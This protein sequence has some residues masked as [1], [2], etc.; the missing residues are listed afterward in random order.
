[1]L[2]RVLAGQPATIKVTF[3]DHNGEPRDA[4]DCTANA[5]RLDGT[6]MSL[7]TPSPGEGVGEFTISL[8]VAQTASLD[9][10][11][12][13]CVETATNATA[14]VTVEIVG[15][16]Y[17]SV[18]EARSTID[19][20]KR[21]DD[22]PTEDVVRVRAE[23]EDE[24]ERICRQAFVPRVKRV[25][26]SGDSTPSLLLDDLRP[27]RIR[28][29]SIDGEALD[30]DALDRLVVDSVGLLSRHLDPF[31]TGIGNIVVIFEHGWD[32]PPSDLKRATLTRLRERLNMASGAI[33][34]RALT[35]SVEG[36]TFSFAVPG[37]G[38]WETGNPDVDAVYFRYRSQSPVFA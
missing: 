13:T 28:S 30:A 3:L 29:F 24:C 6:V 36:A 26:L 33:P 15:G 34:E 25:V 8:S 7:P 14:T 18:T 23:V 1:V 19:A 5:V 11:N 27:R 32:A 16:F 12:I 31:P 35:Q 17:F 21:V 10:L 9:I 20:L 22:Y 37:R 4:S 2:Q 38:Q